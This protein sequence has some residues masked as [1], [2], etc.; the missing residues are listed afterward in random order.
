M[1]ITS[2]RIPMTIFEKLI[3]KKDSKLSNKNLIIKK[4]TDTLIFNKSCALIEFDIL[5]T[6]QNGKAALWNGIPIW[7]NSKWEKGIY[8]NISLIEL[9]LTSEIPIEKT[10]IMDYVDTE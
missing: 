5:E 8:E 10:K 1:T 6:G 3:L 9:D 4:E 7:V 2:E